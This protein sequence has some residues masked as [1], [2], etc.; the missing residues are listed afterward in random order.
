MENIE[1]DGTN[2]FIRLTSEQTAK[3]DGTINEGLVGY[4]LN[5]KWYDVCLDSDEV[6][7]IYL[8]G[9]IVEDKS[10]NGHHGVFHG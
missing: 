9:D 7:K 8:D 1:F 2:D 6:R 3:L 10:G 4:I 5:E